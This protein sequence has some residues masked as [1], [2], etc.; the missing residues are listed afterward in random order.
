MLTTP[1]QGQRPVTT[2]D[3]PIR[4]LVERR[5]SG[6]LTDECWDKLVEPIMEEYERA[7]P[8]EE[9]AEARKKLGDMLRRLKALNWSS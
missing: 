5:T 9:K 7:L 4:I 8:G 3:D 1:I 2:D 6:E